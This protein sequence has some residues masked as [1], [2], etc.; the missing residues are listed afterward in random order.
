[1]TS[2]VGMNSHKIVPFIV[3]RLEAIASRNSD[4]TTWVHLDFQRSH[5][6]FRRASEGA[7]LEDGMKR[8][9]F[10]TLCEN[11]IVSSCLDLS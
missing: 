5:L 4:S 3:I 8:D 1:M 2:I 6:R 7:Q 10:R 11:S 9:S